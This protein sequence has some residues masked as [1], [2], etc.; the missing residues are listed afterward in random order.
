MKTLNYLTLAV[1]L[2]FCGCKKELPNNFQENKKEKFAVTFNTG[3]FSQELKNMS[4][5]N[6]L[7]ESPLTGHA[8]YLIYIIYDKNGK[9]INQIRQD[10]TGKAEHY[11]EEEGSMAMPIGKQS[12]GVIKDSLSSGNYTIIMIASKEKISVNYRINELEYYFKPLNEAFFQ[13]RRGLAPSPPRATD[14]F[15]K[16]FTLNVGNSEIEQNVI[17]N[18]VV[19]KA[20]LNILD[21][22]PNMTF[23]IEY[24]GE[25]DSFR[26]QD[27]SPFGYSLYDEPYNPPTGYDPNYSGPLGQKFEKLLI[28]TTTPIKI[29]IRY[30]DMTK[31]IDDVRIY[32]NKRTVISGNFFSTKTS[33][34]FS[35]SL[36]DE[37]DTDTIK[38]NF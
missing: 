22:Q 19:G 32:K 35:V 31:T 38:V 30:G 36:N 29:I 18:R 23:N 1:F 28:N 12:F 3:D 13:Y 21:A 26:F 9:E 34:A 17:L 5:E 16:K 27:E 11:T 14:T 6:K 25:G 37:F 33:N 15:F 4:K 10:S 24:I 20:E 2:V 7:S 8:G